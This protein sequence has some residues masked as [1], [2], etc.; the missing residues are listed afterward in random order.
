MEGDKPTYVEVIIER[1]GKIIYA[2]TKSVAVNNFA[3]KTIEV[4]LQGKTMTPGFIEP[5]AHPVSIGGFILAN[6]IVAPHEWRM[7]H[8]IYPAV[9]GKEN[10][11]IRLTSTLGNANDRVGV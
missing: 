6:D 4:D 2:G 10:W 1:D 7:P 5:H 8:K 3:G 11:F 9:S